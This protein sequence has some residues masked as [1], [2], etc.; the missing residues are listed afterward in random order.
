MRRQPL[1][2]AL[3]LAALSLTLG[4]AAAADVSRREA[5]LA[6]SLEP[7]VPELVAAA[8]AVKGAWLD[9][10]RLVLRMVPSRWRSAG[11]LASI[12]K[13]RRLVAAT[14]IPRGAVIGVGTW[15][16]AGDATRGLGGRLR[17]VTVVASAP[18]SALEVGS[19][20]DALAA[21]AGG[22]PRVIVSGARLIAWRQV[23]D[24]DGAQGQRSSVDLVTDLAG[25]VELSAAASEGA[26]VRLLPAGYGADR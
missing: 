24:Q 20:V 9:P 23:P 8:P 26:D 4:G 7:L 25:A 3:V 5:A 19:Q 2:R 15:R 16:D 17:A 6:R 1:R 22:R 11:A 21:V 13:G 14:D 12:P 18:L 10:A